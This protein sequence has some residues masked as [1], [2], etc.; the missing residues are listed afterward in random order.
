MAPFEALY[1]RICR[2][3]I[4][5]FDVGEVEL[6]G[7]DLVY[8]AMEKVKLI[9]ERLKTAQSRQ[10]S[11]TDVRR[12]DIEFQVDDWVFLGYYDWVFLG[13]L[14]AVHPVFYVSMLRKCV[15]DPS[16]VVPV[17][18]ITVKDGLTYEEIPIAILDRQGRKLRTKKVA[19]VKVLW[20]S[21]KV[22]EAT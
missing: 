1:G 10:K 12:R 5:S 3:P 2:S 7:L 13:E 6:L 4:G 20:R 17:D 21:Q 8:Q 14:V 9:Q 22:E 16:L 18:S 19:S 15:G 11:Y